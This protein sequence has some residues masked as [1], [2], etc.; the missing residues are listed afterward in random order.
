VALYTYAIT[1]SFPRSDKVLLHICVV[2]F[3]Y[4]EIFYEPLGGPISG[5]KLRTVR[6]VP[7]VREAGA[8]EVTAHLIPIAAAI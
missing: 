7:Y 2:V 8:C 5:Y 3:D 4:L 1:P 6:G